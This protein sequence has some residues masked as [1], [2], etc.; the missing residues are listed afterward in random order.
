MMSESNEMKIDP[1]RAKTLASNIQSIAERVSC[2]AKGRNVSSG[3]RN[4]DVERLRIS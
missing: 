1:A 3:M 4:H 2:A